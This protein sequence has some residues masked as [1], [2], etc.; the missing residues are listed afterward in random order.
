VAYALSPTDEAPF[1]RSLRPQTIAI[2]RAAVTQSPLGVPLITDF[3]P[4]SLR[5]NFTGGF[6]MRFTVGA[7]PLN[8][9]QLGRLYIEGNNGSHVVKLVTAAT[10]VDVPGGS[11]T[12]SLP[13]GTPGQFAYAP[14]EN[15]V[16][17]AANTSYYLISDETDGGDQFYNFGPVTAA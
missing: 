13:S 7:T 10:G 5:N 15:P 16:T 12:V 17:L 1:V 8:V 9:S 2:A 4:G 11:A 14:L 6:G 3:T